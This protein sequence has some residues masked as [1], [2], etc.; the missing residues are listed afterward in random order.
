MFSYLRC[1][2]SISLMEVSI[3]QHS[4]DSS[5]QQ[6]AV[7][8]VVEL[9]RSSQWPP[10]YQPLLIPAAV[11]Q[12][13]R[14]RKHIRWLSGLC[15]THIVGA[16]RSQVEDDPHTV[17]SWADQSGGLYVVYKYELNDGYRLEQQLRYYGRVFQWGCD[18]IH[19]RRNMV[20]SRGFYAVRIPYDERRARARLLAQ[21]TRLATPDDGQTDG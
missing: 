12:G 6:V 4:R 8:E 10:G 7:A 14:Q 15:Q 13:G 9:I 3:L 16:D 5:P 20:T 18:N 17:L 2:N 11:V 1:T 19:L 21:N